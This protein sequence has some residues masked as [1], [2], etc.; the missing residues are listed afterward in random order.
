MQDAILII[1]PADDVHALALAAVLDRDF[2]T[3]AI[4]WDCGTLPLESQ[5]DFRLDE[6]VSEIRFK[7]PAGSHRL[8]DFHSIW[9]RR[10]ASFRIDKSVTDAKVRRF[11]EA[12]C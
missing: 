2:G 10:P 4:I 5:I 8:T 6:S 1:S 3:P 9:W 12:E 7:G 11:C